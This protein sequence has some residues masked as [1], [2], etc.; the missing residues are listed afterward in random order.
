MALVDALKAAEIAGLKLAEGL[1][2]AAISYANIPLVG[3][4]TPFEIQ[5]TLVGAGFTPS[6]QARTIIRK[7]AI[8][9][10]SFKR[11]EAME[12]TAHGSVRN[13]TIVSVN[14]L[15]TAWEITVEDEN[16]GA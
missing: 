1:R 4:I 16:Q 15:A 12:I 3:C 14:E 10:P 5:Q 2:P 8:A 11:G 13:C 9:N 7:T 6:L